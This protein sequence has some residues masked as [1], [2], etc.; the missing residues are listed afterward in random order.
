VVQSLIP[1]QSQLQ[2]APAGQQQQ[3]SVLGQFF[4]IPLHPVIGNVQLHCARPAEDAAI[5]VPTTVA[6]AANA[7]NKRTR[8]CSRFIGRPS[9]GLSVHST[10]LPCNIKDQIVRIDGIMPTR[11]RRAP[12]TV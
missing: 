7:T 1:T 10:P 3:M 9:T 8:T 5:E 12:K 6:I 11:M 4:V 2:P